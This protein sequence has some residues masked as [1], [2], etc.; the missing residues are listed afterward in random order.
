MA[1]S[2]HY[3]DDATFFIKEKVQTQS[4]LP[5]RRGGRGAICRHKSRDL[6]LAAVFIIREEKHSPPRECGSW[7][8]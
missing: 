3:K 4:Q 1:I 6:N 2:T 5:H 8:R 7:S